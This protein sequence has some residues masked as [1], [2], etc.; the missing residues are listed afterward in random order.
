MTDAATQEL[1]AAIDAYV[2]RKYGPKIKID[3]TGHAKPVQR[4]APLGPI[5]PRPMA[6]P[7][8]TARFL[9]APGVSSDLSDDALGL[10]PGARNREDGT[11]DFSLIR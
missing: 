4:F 8:Q 7:A 9:N 2:D 11:I 3:A 6:S 5:D 10:T 1:L